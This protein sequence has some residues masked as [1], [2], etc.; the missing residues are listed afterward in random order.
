MGRKSAKIAARKGA[1]DKAK[2]QIY[3][4]ALKDVFLASKSGSEDPETN[5]LL[6]VAV[7]RAKKFNVPKDVIQVPNLG[8][9][10][11]RTK[12][13]N[14][15]NWIFHCHIDFHLS[16]GMGMGTRLFYP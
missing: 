9:V 4:R 6:R 3:T 15:G 2:G 5:F 13:D 1:A 10:L 16:L 12:L 11:I 7:D 8:Y 14:P